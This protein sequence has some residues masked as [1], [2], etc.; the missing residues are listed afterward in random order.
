M[1][2]D[3]TFIKELK[4]TLI[5][6]LENNNYPMK[7][8]QISNQLHKRKYDVSWQEASL[9]LLKMRCIKRIPHRF[10]FYD[11]IYYIRGKEDYDRE[12]KDIM[13]LLKQIKRKKPK[14]MLKPKPQPVKETTKK[15]EVV[16]RQRL[17]NLY[18]DSKATYNTYADDEFKRLVREVGWRRATNPTKWNRHCGP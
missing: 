3:S 11:D 7:I 2:Q 8:G 12:Q 9:L 16:I 5:E 1:K 10:S 14:P 6:I 17:P 15:K 18:I 4:A 13:K